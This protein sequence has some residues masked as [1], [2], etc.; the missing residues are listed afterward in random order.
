MLLISEFT[1]LVELDCRFLNQNSQ[2]L[3]KEQ[4]MPVLY[5]NSTSFTC[6][7]FR[8]AHRVCSLTIFYFQSKFK[9]SFQFAFDQDLKEVFRNDCIQ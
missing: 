5:F 6:L 1:N 2:L 7:S 9:G 8:F 4:G 3:F